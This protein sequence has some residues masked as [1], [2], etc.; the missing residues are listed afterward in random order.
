MP[1]GNTVHPWHVVFGGTGY[2]LTDAGPV[3]ATGGQRPALNEGKVQYPAQRLSEAAAYANW[4]SDREVPWVARDLSGGFGATIWDG[5]NR[6]L[7]TVGVDARIP[8]KILLAPRVVSNTV[9]GEDRIHEHFERTIGGTTY[10]FICLGR[11]IYYFTAPASVTTSL[12][13][14]TNH[15]AR[16]AV[17]FQGT[18]VDHLTFV[19]ERMAAGMPQPYRMFTGAT[20]TTVWSQ[21]DLETN[22]A[23]SVGIT[24]ISSTITADDATPIVLTLNSLDTSDFAYVAGLQPFEGLQIDINAT[25]GTAATLT[26]KY[27][28]GSAWA[29]VSSLVDGSASGGAS[30]AQDGAITWTLPTDWGITSITATDGVVHTGY[31]VRLNWSAQLDATVTTTDINLRQRD[32][33]EFFEVHDASIFRIAKQANGWILYSAPDGGLGA[34]WT[35]VGIITDLSNNVTGMFSSGTR[36]YILTERT[37]HV[38]ADDGSK[39]DMEVWPHPRTLQDS[40]NGVGASPARGKLFVPARRDLYTL[41]TDVFGNISIDDKVGPNRILDNS[42]PVSGRITCVAG[43]DY[44]LYAVLQNSGGNSYLMSMNYETGAW[45]TLNDLGAIT[46]R[47]MWI[48]DVG[49]SGNPVLYFNAGTDLRHIVLQ[50]NG[51]DPTNDDSVAGGNYEYYA[52]TDAYI[53]LPRFFSQFDFETKAWLTGKVLIEDTG[54]TETVRFEYRVSPND[55]WSQLETYSSDPVGSTNFTASVAGRFM[56]IRI[57]LLGS[58]TATPKLRRIWTSYAVRYPD[59]S[60]FGFAVRVANKQKNR[61]GQVRAESAKQLLDSLEN[62]VSSSTPVT[63]FIPDTDESIDVIPTDRR[64]F[65]DELTMRKQME[66]IV[67]VTAAKH[68]NTPQGTWNLVS[69]LTWNQA[70]SHTWS[71]LATL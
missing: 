19:A 36:L 56:E 57:R 67:Y 17:N 39:I 32:T 20:V 41:Q 71:G 38:L 66:W 11:Y 8:G 52:G 70:A 30:F 27:W 40:L 69:G 49:A 16:S 21:D 2:I 25:N 59:K 47:H 12:D 26:L 45:H 4:P 7:Y 51:P 24:D 29:T 44:Y 68:Q 33:A 46:C 23:P 1:V 58:T 62:T 10:Q 35:Q 34:T 28:T 61:N 14:G 15:V 48:S 55:G 13:M 64:R 60:E 22:V 31:F 18:H 6:Y 53:Y 43:D 54:A 37:P 65:S 9:T 42:S 5:S 63:L 50:M 3:D